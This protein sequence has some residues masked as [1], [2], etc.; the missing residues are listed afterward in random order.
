MK[1]QT[2]NRIITVLNTHHYARLGLGYDFQGRKK[3]MPI[4]NQ[5]MITTGRKSLRYPF[6]KRSSCMIYSR[7]LAMGRTLIFPYACPKSVSYALMT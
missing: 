6:K 7:G 4:H 2:E 3:C 1:L 5:G